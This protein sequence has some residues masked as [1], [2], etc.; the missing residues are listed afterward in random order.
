LP[1]MGGYCRVRQVWMAMWEIV[2]CAGTGKRQK[3][4]QKGLL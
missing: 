1:M 3:A 2:R 4:L